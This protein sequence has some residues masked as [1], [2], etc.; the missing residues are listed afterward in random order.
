MSNSIHLFASRF[1]SSHYRSQWFPS[2]ASSGIGKHHHGV[3][4]M[5]EKKLIDRFTN[6]I[7]SDSES[8]DISSEPESSCAYFLESASPLPFNSTSLGFEPL[9]TRQDRSATSPT[10]HKRPRASVLLAGL[11]TKK[12]TATYTA[13]TLPIHTQQPSYLLFGR[14]TAEESGGEPPPYHHC[15]DHEAKSSSYICHCDCSRG[16]LHISQCFTNDSQLNNK[17]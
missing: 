16:R 4:L 14:A 9:N 12:H 15:E 17:K 2:V 1:R 13:P 5:R 11:I 7:Q 8:L 10:F 6:C 3:P